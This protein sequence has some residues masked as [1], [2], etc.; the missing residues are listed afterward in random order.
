[1]AI[2]GDLALC[3]LAISQGMV[4]AQVTLRVDVLRPKCYDGSMNASELDNFFGGRSNSL[5]QVA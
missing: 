4:N 5:R 2:K 1:M 3:K